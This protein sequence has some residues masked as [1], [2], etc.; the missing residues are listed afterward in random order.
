MSLYAAWTSTFYTVTFFTGTETTLPSQTVQRGGK[1]SAPIPAPTRTGYELSAW[2]KDSSLLVMWNFGADTVVSNVPLF[3]KWTKAKYDVTFSYQNGKV[4]SVSSVTHGD[5]V[6]KPVQ[7]PIKDGYTFDNWYPPRSGGIPWNFATTVTAPCTLYAQ[8]TLNRYQVTL[9]ARNGST[10]TSVT[11]N[12]GNLVTKPANPTRDGYDFDKWYAEL[13]CTT[14]WNFNSPVTQPCTLY[15]QWT[16]KRYLIVFNSMGGS[17]ISSVYI[18]HGSTVNR[19]DSV[20]KFEGY[21]FD[22]WYKEASGT[23]LW[24]FAAD[25]IKV[26][27]TIFAKWVEDSTIIAWGKVENP[28]AK[29]RL[30]GTMP[31]YEALVANSKLPDPFMKLNGTR[32]TNKSD[33]A[34][35]REE[36]RQQLL[37]YVFG[38]KPIPA[39]GSVTGTVTT[40]KITVNVNEGGKSCSFEVTVDMNGATQPAPSII[41]YGSMGGASAPNGV[42][43]ITF[44]A[45]ETTGGSGAKTGPFYTFYG[46]T[47]PA[48]YLVAQA[49][50]ISRIIDVME[51]NP[52]IFDPYRVGVTGCSHYGK[53][54]FVA[55]TL[56]NRIALT[57]PC[58][59]G[60]GGTVA[61]RLVEQL[62]QS[63]EWPYHAITYVRWLSEVALG[64]FTTANSAI[65]DNT[66]RLPVDMH[67]A[68]ALIAP[69]AIY[70]VDNASTSYAGLDKNSSYVT[71]MVGK[72]IF[73]ALGVGDNFAYECASGEYCSWRSQYNTSL[74]AMIDKFL[75]NKTS[76]TGAFNS[77]LS[78][79]PNP[80]NFYDWSASE[81]PGS[82]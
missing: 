42:A 19:P 77:D 7:T 1:I 27:D 10:A 17:A 51:L 50:Q 46:S 60:I 16:I 55:G 47:H 61:L 22:N 78:T 53:G 38:D 72:E 54:A 30:S 18:N 44:T 24:N 25:T 14:P 31:E 15:A 67:S 70:I 64:K 23:T 56:D 71:G 62:D 45:I 3:A 12:H 40:S 74:N 5:T 33:W 79:K 37:K 52:G 13:S 57:I 63:G 35:R 32:I 4:D 43:K 29:C 82:F 69:R 41:S 11:V 73:K 59:S 75:L 26:P 76:T 8:W 2:Y 6:I 39:K 80:L 48:G 28:T 58:E 49:W 36:I 66:D 65:G 81:L 21:L 34:C 9:N 68:M 20:P